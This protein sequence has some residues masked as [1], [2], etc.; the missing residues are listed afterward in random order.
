MNEIKTKLLFLCN[1]KVDNLENLK[2]NF[3]SIDI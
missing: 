1:L 2:G 3:N